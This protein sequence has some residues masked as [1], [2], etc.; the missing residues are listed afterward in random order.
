MRRG[1]TGTWKSIRTGDE[2][3][4]AFVPLPLP[5]Q[6]PLEIDSR[7][8]RKQ[9]QA[10]VALGRL[11]T[12]SGLLPASHLFLYHYVRR[13]AVLSSQIEGTQSSLSDLLRHEVFQTVEKMDDVVET[14]LYVAAMV[15]GLERLGEG[16]P[17]CN[18][19]LREMHEKLLA[20]G[21]GSSAAV[22][23]FRKSQNWIGGSRPGDAHYVP[24]PHT[25]VEACM[26]DLESF[27]HDETIP[28]L[29]KAALAHVQFETIHPF[30]DGNGRIGRLL[31]ALVLHHE[32]L[33]GKS[34]LYLSLYF[35]R[36]RRRYYRL[37]DEVRQTGNWESWLAFFFTGVHEVAT[38]AVDKAHKLTRLFKQDHECIKRANVPLS[39]NAVHEK[40][41]EHPFNTI[42]GLAKAAG[43]S[44]PTTQRALKQ[45]F[46][47]GI[48]HEVPGRRRN[49]AFVY[50]QYLDI[51]N[52]GTDTPAE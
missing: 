24:P 15:H 16:F 38:E 32:K 45:L 43:F 2:T 47:L 33:L 25:D 40:L 28:A 14:S 7:L 22:G 13:E 18:R 19:L 21:R 5:P 20:R 11:D 50:T 37:L 26:A 1:L 27:L 17:L 48:V 52:E 30:L 35:K 42:G 31:I 3:V 29:T 8:Q 23:E 44:Y 10:L 34:L 36:N 4:R 41:C 49:R 39:V 12:V 51:L 6:Q 46:K 9:E